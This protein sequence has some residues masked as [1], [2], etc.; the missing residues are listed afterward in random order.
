MPLRETPFLKVRQLH[1]IGIGGIGMSGIARICHT[2][3]YHVAG[4]DLKESEMVRDLRDLGLTV[5]IGHRRE[6]L[7]EAQVV[8]TS[9]A[10]SPGNPEL[11][12]AVERGTP[13]IQRGEMLAELMRLK[14]GIA[15]AGTHGKT[16]TTAMVSAVLMEGGLSP[17]TVVGGKWMAINSNAELGKSQFLVCESDESDGSFLKLSPV[18]TVV[19]NIDLDH[20]DHYK[21]EE[22]LQL[23]FLQFINKTPFYGKA[24]LC[25]DDNR[26]GDLLSE[27]E[28]PR[29]TYGFSPKAT[30]RAENMAYEDGAMVFDVR[31]AGEALGRFH[32]RI[33]GRHN[34]LNAL[35]AIAVGLELEVPVDAIRR[36]LDGFRGVARRM[37]AVGRLGGWNVVDDYGHHPTE[38]RA[39]MEA[40]RLTTKKLSVVFQPH[41]YS[42][43]L[44]LYREFAEVLS[45]ADRVYLLDIYAAGE[46]AI[47]DVTSGLIHERLSGHPCA[48]WIKEREGLKARLEADHAGGE[49]VIL[50]IGA[51]DVYRIGYGLCGLEAP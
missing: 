40:V 42:R 14:Y 25:A 44:A 21:T 29:L 19:T 3:G 15:V 17:T 20:M 4:S 37:T 32:L 11:R 22:N 35:A 5:H 51:G 12:A 6:N 2:L 46:A 7:G 1:F 26:L 31:L 27:V 23:S 9:S 39:T 28:K 16:T 8:V 30:L 33:P 36:G 13:V 24:I 50:T 48:H 38:L 41:R 45:L 43:T 47:P 10:V 34:V 18:I 49:G